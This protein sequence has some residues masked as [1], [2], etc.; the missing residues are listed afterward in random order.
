MRDLSMIKCVNLKL[1]P[2]F[3]LENKFTARSNV[4]FGI[5]TRVKP[6]LGTSG[7]SLPVTVPT[8]NT[9]SWWCAVELSIRHGR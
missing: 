4:A 1:V 2:A 3:K 5:A 6:R 7:D 8:G 9:A